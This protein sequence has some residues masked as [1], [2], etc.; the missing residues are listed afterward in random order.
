MDK[1]IESRK[2]LQERFSETFSFHSKAIEVS[3]TEHQFLDRLK[4]ALE[5]HLTEPDFNAEKLSHTMLMSRMQL[6][7]KLKALTSLTTSEFIRSE[8]LK[9]ALPLLEASDDTIS[10]IAYKIGFNTPSYFIKSFKAVYMCT[11]SEY[12]SK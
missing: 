7:R 4:Q 1:L 6:H 9:L 8:R 5:A 11:P 2:R 3:S 12:K 10:E